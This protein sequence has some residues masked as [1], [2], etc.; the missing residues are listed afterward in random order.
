MH[1][2]VFLERSTYN[3]DIERAHA[4]WE[5]MNHNYTL[6]LYDTSSAI[7]KLR[8]HN[9]TG[10]IDAMNN[11]R[12]KGGKANL[13]RFA[14]LWAE[15]GWYTD[16]KS[17]CIESNILD[18]IGRAS[19]NS[20]VTCRD[21]GNHYSIKNRL[22]QNAFIGAPPRDPCIL[23]CIQAMLRNV[24]M[25]YYGVNPLDTTGVGVWGRIVQAYCPPKIECVYKNN[26]FKYGDI[27]II[28][29][30]CSNC[31]KGQDWM[32]GNNYNRLWKTRT[33]YTADRHVVRSN[34]WWPF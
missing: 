30:K 21:D 4:S 6:R 10:V 27:A 20:L 26:L 15:G 8:Q 33:Y 14:V 7:E 17:E 13:F 25:Q 16:W 5:S 28:R 1:K 23:K 34:K 11:V 31:A 19:K 3:A 18:R 22:Y 24:H 2:V 9:L 12:A 29:H 32:H